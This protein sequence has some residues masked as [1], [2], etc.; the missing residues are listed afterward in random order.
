VTPFGSLG[1]PKPCSYSKPLLLPA[2]GP[3]AR[4]TAPA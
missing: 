1:S 2:S 3:I 4:R